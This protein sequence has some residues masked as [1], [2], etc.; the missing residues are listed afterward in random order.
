[1][2]HTSA[3][4]PY[5]QHMSVSPN[6]PPTASCVTLLTPR[7]PSSLSLLALRFDCH[8]PILYSWTK[9]IVLNIIVWEMMLKFHFCLTDKSKIRLQI[10]WQ[11]HCLNYNFAVFT[12]NSGSVYVV[13]TATLVGPYSL[14]DAINSYREWIGVLGYFCKSFPFWKSF[15][16][17]L[18]N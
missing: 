3:F 11:S 15:Q 5:P 1:M 2:V 12:T 9:H 17:W 4:Q 16:Y 14:N 8:S 13:V 7:N 18:E 10:S 6:A